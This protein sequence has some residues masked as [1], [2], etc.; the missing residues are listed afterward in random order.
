VRSKANM[1][2]IHRTPLL[3]NNVIQKNDNELSPGLIVMYENDG[4]PLLASI[5]D[6]KKQ[7]HVVLNHRGREAEMTP[8][9]LYSFF[10][11]IP[12]N[13]ST[14]EAKVGFLN[15]LMEQANQN[16]S[17]LNL[18]E[19]WS[20]VHEEDRHFSCAELCELYFG[21]KELS[22]HLEL[23]L[24][25]LSDKVYFKR[26]KEEFTP[27]SKEV[28]ED[29]KIAEEE[30]HRKLQ[31]HER[32][33]IF[34]EARLKDPSVPIPEEIDPIIDLLKEI[35]AD[36]P[37]IDGS[38]HREAKELLN[39]CSEKLQITLAGR[40]DERVY[41]FLR[42]IKIFNKNSNLYLLRHRIPVAFP[43]ECMNEARNLIN[44]IDSTKEDRK[45]YTH[46][47]AY[48]IDDSST[49]DMDDAISLEETSNGFRLGIHISDVASFITP[50]SILDKVAA[51]RATSLYFPDKVINMLPEALSHDTFSLVKDKQR[52]CISCF[53]QLNSKFEI[54][55]WEIEKTWI[56]VKIRYNYEE[57][58]DIL[59]GSNREFQNLH[60]I[61]A[62]NE[63]R[64]LSQ[65]GMRITKKDAIVVV[66]DDGSLRLQEIDEDSPA[67]SLVSELMVLA[68]EHFG[69]FAKQN[70]LALVFR[71]QDAPDRGHDFNAEKIPL[72]PARDLFVRLGLKKSTTGAYP[73]SHHTLGLSVY[74]QATSPIRRYI[75]ICNQRQ[76]LSLLNKEPPTYLTK[77]LLDRIG[78][79]DPNLSRAN[80]AS[81]ESKRF[82]LMNY[83]DQNYKR[84]SILEGTI[85]RLDLKAPMVELD[86]FYFSVPVKLK[87]AGKLGDRVKLR[88][89]NISPAFDYIKLEEC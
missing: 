76:I 89:E 1:T 33:L 20:L 18:A 39:N 31:L 65:G 69:L 56:K 43:E 17:A 21:S 47:N 38:K 86:N 32:A 57:V 85:V 66:K 42:S 68:N 83:I 13:C 77:T 45:N 28:I 24:S 10:S 44:K 49:K 80:I 14:R 11:N 40:Q 29:L 64:R 72:G 2:P 75:D 87:K 55:K 46:L 54:E 67:R 52:A 63:M 35:A 5:L 41:N 59:D 26:H 34:F 37:D 25:L 30:R 12:S 61:C 27:R 19:I 36:C 23:R 15:K 60:H 78:E 58:D 88:L 73:T 51:H 3:R 6:Y 22:K 48:T 16:L 74:C 7:R 53:F 81:R 71:G 62:T 79:I 4:K 84:G 8:E 50:D 82:W 9:R 70:N